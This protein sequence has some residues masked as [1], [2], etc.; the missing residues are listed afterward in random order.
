M[1]KTCQRSCFEEEH[2]VTMPAIGCLDLRINHHPTMNREYHP[3][4]CKDMPALLPLYSSPLTPPGSSRGSSPNEMPPLAPIITRVRRRG[5]TRGPGPTLLPCSVCGDMA[6]DHM[7]YGGIVCFSC[8]AF[9]RRSVDK[10]SNYQCLE[11]MNCTID[12]G[13]RRS[14]Q[15]CRFQKCLRAGMKPTWV[16]SEEEKKQRTLRKKVNSA[17]KT[18]SQY[19]QPSTTTQP[20][21]EQKLT[22]PMAAHGLALEDP[23]LEE[24]LYSQENTRHTVTLPLN[25]SQELAALSLGVLPA[26]SANGMIEFYQVMYSRVVKFTSFIREFNELRPSDMKFLLRHNLEPMVIVRLAASFN[27]L[28]S[29]SQLK[30]LGRPGIHMGSQ[31]IKIEQVFHTPWAANEKHMKT[32][33]ETVNRLVSLPYFDSNICILLQLVTLFSTL[34]LDHSQIEEPEKIDEVQE[35]FTYKLLSYLRRKML[36]SQ[37]N[38]LVHKYLSVLAELRT[39]A[40]MVTNRN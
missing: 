19:Q 4:V 1:C 25:C 29:V 7:H 32:Y 18:T 17:Q 38:G 3:D 27:P 35:A 23:M 28:S 20:M 34:G 11:G 24:W 12:V 21:F 26:L 30:E 33:C 2:L 15:F 13:S 6:P 14:C 8:R 16:L 9:F 36:P 40:E 31:K 5:R 37:S 22:I 39:L 10:S